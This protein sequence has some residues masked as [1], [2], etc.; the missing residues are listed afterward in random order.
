MLLIPGIENN[1]TVSRRINT[2]QTISIFYMCVSA[3]RRAVLGG[4]VRSQGADSHP[5]SLT[6]G[7]AG[8]NHLNEKS[9]PLLPTG[10]GE[11]YR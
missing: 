5:P 7:K 10:I 9:I 8:R 4:E 6:R 2:P 1:W 3:D 11:Q